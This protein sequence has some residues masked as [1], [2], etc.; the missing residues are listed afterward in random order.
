LIDWHIFVS[1]TEISYVNN[2]NPSIETNIQP[3]S[4]STLFEC[5][6]ADRFEE[7]TAKQTPK[8]KTPACDDAF[9]QIISRWKRLIKADYRSAENRHISA[10]FN[11]LILVRGC[12]DQKISTTQTPTRFLTDILQGD[13]HDN[14]DLETIIS[15][16]LKK[17]GIN[18]ELS[19]FVDV[20]RLKPFKSFDKGTA[21]EMCRDFYRPI[22][23]LY[24]FNFAL[25]SKHALSRI[26]ERYVSLL[27]FEAEDDSQLSFIAPTPS[28]KL[29]TKGGSVYTPQ[30][31]AGFFARYLQDNLTPRAF[32]NLRLLDPACGSG[33]FL[34]TLLEVQC[35][36]L[37][38]GTTLQTITAAFDAVTAIDRDPNAC[39]ATFLSL[40]LLHLV[41]TGN[42]PQKLDIRNKDAIALIQSKN[43]K[44]ESFG[45]IIANP[46]Y[47][48]LDNLSESEVKVVNEYLGETNAGRADT[49]L[50]FV[51]LCTEAVAQGGFVCLVLPQTFLFAKNAASLRDQI[52]SKFHIR[53]VIDLSSIRV[54]E[55]VGTYNI[56]LII[57]KRIA[58][59]GDNPV[60]Q[61]AKVQEFVGPALQACLEHKIVETPY[62][63]VFE[64]SQ[65]YFEKDE[66][67][68]LAPRDIILEEKINRFRP[69]SEY[70]NVMQGFVSGA[71]SIFILPKKL[72][73]EGEEAIYVDYL[74]DKSIYRYR[75][76]Q[77]P[78]D[79]IFYPFLEGKPLSESELKK[80]FPRTWRYLNS[81]K[82]A[83][84]KRRAVTSGDSPWWKPV[85]S[86]DPKNLLRPKI[87]CPHLMLTP[88]FA[89]DTKGKFAVSH[90]PFFVTKEKTDELNILKFFCA[91]LNSSVSHWFLS[92]Y[93]PKYGHGY[94]RVEVSSLKSLPVPDP[95]SV[96]PSVMREILDA[97]S[98]FMRD[99]PS[100]E[101]EA[102]IDRRIAALYGLTPSEQ[103]NVLG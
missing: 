73:P 87:V 17:C 57:Q 38:P 52:A 85:R 70:L 24:E 6:S 8:K 25:M 33:I 43:L 39:E 49:Y 93:L 44:V 79:A 83:L 101:I 91:V 4:R 11:A 92:T 2:L 75:L 63:N 27:D 15:S 46:P 65:K 59:S 34:R 20:E 80:I 53:C 35:N 66:W 58:G 103:E 100:S 21:L 42:L 74:P 68:L 77:R 51:K 61:V 78:T 54:F 89:I 31:V 28:E 26:Y 76:P 48:K 1:E 22:S 67:S 72:V 13:P 7:F 88:R 62:Y 45:A 3:I 82:D 37:I 86:R 29:N 90:T 23:S 60:A 30:Y 56:L 98:S 99:G 14:V 10:L 47:I 50:A 19:A 96:S 102:R 36:P 81:H 69:I 5:L 71:D 97:V 12:E 95:S 16:A 94:K 84:S 55:G 64:V 40:A 32:R 9:I 41:A 18:S